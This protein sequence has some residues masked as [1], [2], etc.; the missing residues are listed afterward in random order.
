MPLLVRQAIPE[1]MEPLDPATLLTPENSN[2]W[3]ELSLPPPTDEEI[4]EKAAAQ[5]EADEQAAKALQERVA[6]QKKKLE[7][8]NK[9]PAPVVVPAASSSDKSS[10]T[11]P[12]VEKTDSA[13]S[14]VNTLRS[15]VPSTATSETQQQD[16]A[17]A[18]AM[19]NDEN[20]IYNQDNDDE[21]KNTT[22]DAEKPS[23]QSEGTNSHVVPALSTGIDSDETKDASVTLPAAN[24]VLDHRTVFDRAAE[25]HTNMQESSYAHHAPSP[26]PLKPH[27]ANDEE[28]QS[29]PP[30]GTRPL[31]ERT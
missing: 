10:A 7:T 30:D 8:E 17:I 1:N 9:K 2:G 11:Q 21:A 16:A 20:N 25:D 28:L 31:D 5:K 18:A 4:A 14:T 24:S 19:A 26:V 23:S 29:K 27:N 12:V 3:Q 13:A 6:E 15:A 22:D